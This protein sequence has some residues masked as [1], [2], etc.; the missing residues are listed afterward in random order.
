MQKYIRTEQGVFDI[1]KEVKKV[2]DSVIEEV[3][4][5]YQLNLESARNE[6]EYNDLKEKLKEEIDNIKVKVDF[7]EYFYVYVE[8]SF[9]DRDS[10]FGKIIKSSDTIEELVDEYVSINKE[11][12]F[13]SLIEIEKHG[14][15]FT[16]DK[17]TSWVETLEKK[18]KKCDIYGSIW[19][20]GN[21]IKVAKMNEKGELEL[22]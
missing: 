13:H 17:I 15:R 5:S 18:L 11:N 14:N 1:E 20:D 16:R 3:N 2:L 21:L 4:F 7:N 6:N 19:V 22:L 10:D 12:K 9:T 8:A